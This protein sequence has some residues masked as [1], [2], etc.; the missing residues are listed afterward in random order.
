MEENAQK[1]SLNP[2]ALSIAD[3]ALLL[4]KV[5]GQPV[6]ASMIEADRAAVLPPMP[7]APSTWFT[8]PPGCSRRQD[9]ATDPRR[10]RPTQLCGSELNAARRGNHTESTP[11]SP[12][13]CRSAYR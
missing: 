10:L 6:T 9:V 1:S 8:M 11:A 4:T 13:P 7:M 3:A 2:A 12:R 5:G